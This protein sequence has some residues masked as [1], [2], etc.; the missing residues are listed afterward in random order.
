LESRKI[1][2]YLITDEKA[3]FSTSKV[4]FADITF[5]NGSESIIPFNVVNGAPHETEN[6]VR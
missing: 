1:E 2:N 5:K 4:L 3:D 6:I